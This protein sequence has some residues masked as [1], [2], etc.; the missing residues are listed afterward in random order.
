LTS[1]NDS[2]NCEAEDFLPF[3]AKSFDTVEVDSTF[4]RVPSA[5]T[6][7]QW[8]ERTPSGFTFSAKVP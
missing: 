7:E 4:Y 5:K 3:C 2:G 8:R 6:V 1:A